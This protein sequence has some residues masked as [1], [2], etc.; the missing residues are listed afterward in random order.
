MQNVDFVESLRRRRNI[1]SDD[2]VIFGDDLKQ[3][4]AHLSQTN[5]DN[6]L[7]RFH[8]VFVSSRMNLSWTESLDLFGLAVECSMP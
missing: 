8:C 3:R 1:H 7:S 4:F 2:I 6:S 5:D